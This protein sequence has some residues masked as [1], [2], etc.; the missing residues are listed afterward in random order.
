MPKS[1]DILTRDEAK[2]LRQ[3]GWVFKTAYLSQTM[4]PNFPKKPNIIVYVVDAAG[5]R[6]YVATP[7]EK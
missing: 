2:N 5:K 1:N 6:P 7:P 3:Q 4:G